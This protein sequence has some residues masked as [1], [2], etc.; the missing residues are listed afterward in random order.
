MIEAKRD[1]CETFYSEYTPAVPDD[2]IKTE[3]TVPFGQSKV[4]ETKFGGFQRKLSKTM[5][6]T[7]E[8]ELNNDSVLMERTEQ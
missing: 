6:E 5:A 4:S 1:N 8:R 3:K 2:E 7:S